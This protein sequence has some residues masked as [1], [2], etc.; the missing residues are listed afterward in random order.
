MSSNIFDFSKKNYFM[1][2]ATSIDVSRIYHASLVKCK[3]LVIEAQGSH[4]LKEYC[5]YDLID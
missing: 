1:L 2:F 5:L 4:F 3:R